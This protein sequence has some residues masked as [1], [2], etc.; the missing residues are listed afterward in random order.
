MV[1]NDSVRMVVA[2][3][4]FTNASVIPPMI[5]HRPK[6]VFE[7]H[8]ERKARSTGKLV[9]V[10][11]ENCSVELF[12]QL[13]KKHTLVDAT[14]QERIDNKGPRKGTYHSVNFTFALREFAKTSPEFEEVKEKLRLEAR[15]I[16][17]EAFWTISVWNNPFF[18]A[19]EEV[20]GYRT[21]AIKA[22]ARKPLFLPDGKPV[23]ARLKKDG[24]PYGDPI[25]LQPDHRLVIEENTIKLVKA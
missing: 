17:R 19:G 9:I 2:S 22:V 4:N 1:L 18:V 25:P 5:R 16:F 24:K 10:P 13:D 12:D 14:Y 21:V 23:V 15:Q 7:E 6:E 11:A 20:D 8:I 3:I